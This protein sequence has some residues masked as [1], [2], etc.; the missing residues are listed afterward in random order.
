MQNNVRRNQSN[1]NHGLDQEMQDIFRQLFPQEIQG[2]QG[3]AQAGLGTYLNVIWRRKW[4]VIVPLLIFPV[5]ALLLIVLERPIYQTT[6]TLMI[7]PTNQKIV[8][9][10]E[11]V[12]PDRSRDYTQTQYALLRSYGMAEKVIDTL[13]RRTPGIGEDI[14][15]D[16][17]AHSDLLGV[18][19]SLAE[20]ILN[21]IKDNITN[22]S[23]KFIIVI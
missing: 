4:I 13:S 19:L 8:Q 10:E 1:E 7:E 18:E 22:T 17:T 5:L 2:A 20:S 14:S 9:F 23:K 15:D 11:V 16:D 12:Q 3:N 6:A 21:Y